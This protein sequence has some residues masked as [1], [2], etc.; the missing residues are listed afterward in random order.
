MP[1]KDP[2]SELVNGLISGD[3]VAFAKIFEKY[4]R[5]VYAFALRSFRN[6]EDAE[7]A[8]QD[9]FYQ[10]WK[11]RSKLKELKDLEAW[12]FKICIN[13]VRKHFRKL[14][15]EKK[16]LKHF[17]EHYLEGDY[18]T[19]AD[20]EY[21]DLL[22]KTERIVEKLPPRQKE[23]FRLSRK[24]SL[25]NIQISEKLEISVRTVDNQLSKAKI[26]IRN[27]L[28]EENILALLFFFLFI[29]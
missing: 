9:V 22:E 1:E 16:H 4:F 8:V 28:I 23:I 15:V 25:S 19:V 17:K 26:F 21:K 3:P 24:E 10:L 6:P 20:I 5:K 27:V 18:S 7:G 11:D 14:A 2:E 13:I 29:D 12:I